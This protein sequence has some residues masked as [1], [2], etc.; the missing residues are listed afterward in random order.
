M[1]GSNL[2]RGVGALLAMAWLTQ[3]GIAAAAVPSHVDRL[4]ART[5][6]A[7][8]TATFPITLVGQTSTICAGLCYTLNSSPP[9]T[10]D[11][12][13]PEAIDH[14]VSP[15]FLANHYVVGAVTPACTGTPVT[16]PTNLSAHQV[17]WFD[18]NFSP[19]S[20]GS[21]TDTLTISG[22]SLFLS[23]STGSPA[24]PV[25]TLSSLGLISLA[26][27]LA[28]MGLIAARRARRTG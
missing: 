9:G 10:C 1:N 26:L 21:F 16:L 8:S 28:G 15:P 23:G 13:G 4:P 22:F 5:A 27:L 6:P 19:T 11:G 18:I 17:L 3:P 2:G 20:D 12:S 25:P 7:D 14:D 24:T